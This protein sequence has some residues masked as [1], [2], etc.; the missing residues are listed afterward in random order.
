[1]SAAVIAALMFASCKPTENNY[2]AA[3]DA[4]LEKREAVAREQM[5]PVTG[6]LSDDGPQMKILEGDT[7]FVLKELLY[8][9]EPSEKVSGWKV[10]VGL[11][12]M[13]TNAKA[14]AVDLQDSGWKNAFAARAKVDKVSTLDSA[15]VVAKEFAKKHK[16][17]PYIGLPNSPVLI[18]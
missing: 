10:A 8:R 6:L 12:K 7:V 4:A 2:K 16:T 5:L 11:Y 14:N 3:Y 13:E 1:M 17:Y 15:R 18:N 9:G